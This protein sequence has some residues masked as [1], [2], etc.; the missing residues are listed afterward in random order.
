[1][2]KNGRRSGPRGEKSS[3]RLNLGKI[4]ANKSLNSTSYE[5]S[6]VFRTNR[7]FLLSF[8]P[9]TRALGGEI[10]PIQKKFPQHVSQKFLIL[11]T[12]LRFAAAAFRYNPQFVPSL[13][14]FCA[15]SQR[16]APSGKRFVAEYL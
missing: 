9:Q 3:T 11:L 4:T 7:P 14:R 16:A 6:T 15:A 10:V 2:E 5:Y 12:L 1:M 13:C 8:F